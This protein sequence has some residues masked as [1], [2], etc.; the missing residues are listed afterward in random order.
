MF[1]IAISSVKAVGDGKKK[2]MEHG[3]Q[4]G[5]YNGSAF[6]TSVLYLGVFFLV[7]A[8]SFLFFYPM[9]ETGD[10]P[11]VTTTTITAKKN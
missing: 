8:G 10:N 2:M 9:Q 7:L 5:F 1:H 11:L 3:N 4:W 6:C